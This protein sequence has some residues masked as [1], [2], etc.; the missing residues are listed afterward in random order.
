MQEILRP[1][2]MC[3]QVVDCVLFCVCDRSKELSAGQVD[4]HILQHRGRKRGSIGQYSLP[5]FL[6]SL[7]EP[8]DSDHT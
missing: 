3:F 1:V 5:D 8:A 7:S 4:G 2:V 6:A